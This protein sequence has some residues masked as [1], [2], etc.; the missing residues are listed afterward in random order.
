MNERCG[1]RRSFALE[2]Q[3]V[4]VFRITIILTKKFLPYEKETFP[5]RR[6]HL[7]C[8]GMAFHQLFCPNKIRT[9]P[10]ERRSCCN[11]YGCNKG[12]ATL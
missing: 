4:A 2:N 11:V 5:Y 12:R 10:T 1:S 8:I 6:H 3:Q 9:Q 7:L